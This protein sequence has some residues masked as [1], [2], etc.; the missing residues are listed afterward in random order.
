[1]DDNIRTIQYLIAK[2][3][4]GTSPL[5]IV[6]LDQE[7]AYGRVSHVLLWAALRRLGI[8]AKLTKLIRSLYTGAVI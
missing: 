4:D 6:F 3:K 1:M 7:K 8:P 5:A 2:Y